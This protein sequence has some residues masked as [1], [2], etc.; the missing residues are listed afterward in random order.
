MIRSPALQLWTCA[1]TEAGY[2]PVR[3]FAYILLSNPSRKSMNN[4]KLSIVTSSKKLFT[5]TQIHASRSSRNNVGRC[6][7]RVL[8]VDRL[9]EV[10]ESSTRESAGW[11]WSAL[12]QPDLGLWLLLYGSADRHDRWE[13][14]KRL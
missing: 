14:L 4:S 10:A 13:Q 2:P 5:A 11:P 3:C 1:D 8:E 6:E 12:K 9:E 7:N